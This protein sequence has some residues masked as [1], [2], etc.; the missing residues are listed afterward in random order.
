MKKINVLRN[1][2]LLLS[3]I[4]FVIAGISFDSL[5]REMSQYPR[6][7]LQSLDKISAHTMTFEA[8]V[9]DTLKFGSLYIRVQSCQKSS[10]MD[11]PEA[12]AFLQ[13]WEIDREGKSQWIF[14]GWMFA[15]SP[16]LSSLDHPI[17]DVWVI[18]CL[19]NK[20]IEDKNEDAHN[21][22]AKEKE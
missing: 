3:L 4:I 9:G 20:N 18:D 5:S 17:H 11:K 6:I 10:P 8:N 12:A 22:K 7:K 21:K 2:K 14:S 19:E 16:G 13:I 1:S 15:S